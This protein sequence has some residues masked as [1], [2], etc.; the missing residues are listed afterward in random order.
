MSEIRL[1][2]G[3]TTLEVGI[4]TTIGTR[5]RQEDAAGVFGNRAAIFEGLGGHEGGDVASLAA[6]QAFVDPE[7]K[8]LQEALWR[9]DRAVHE[10][11]RHPYS[12]TTVAAM[13]YR[14]PLRWSARFGL[15]KAVH[16]HQVAVRWAGDSRVYLFRPTPA[17]PQLSQLTRDHHN[18]MGL[19]LCLGGR[20]SA[21]TE[22]VL[23]P[24]RPGDFILLTT[25]GVHGIPFDMVGLLWELRTKAAESI[26]WE[27]LARIRDRAVD[28]ATMVL[29]KLP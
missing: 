3:E 17:R 25:D 16:E 26:V 9:A 15:G 21:G 13:E 23:H 1:I 5:S 27:M 18:G 20:G 6:V 11:R 2:R 12:G 19:T 10:T 8:T 29:I 4:A 28:N 24:V 22:E 14:T 7:V